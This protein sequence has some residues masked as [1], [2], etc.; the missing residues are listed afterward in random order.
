MGAPLL[1]SYTVRGLTRNRMHGVEKNDVCK[2]PNVAAGVRSVLLDEFRRNVQAQA[3][4]TNKG[5]AA[6]GPKPAFWLDAAAQKTRP[7][8]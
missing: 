7:L 4:S 8:A 3:P 5:P 6:A 2:V 1:L